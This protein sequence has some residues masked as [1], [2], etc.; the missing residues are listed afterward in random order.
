MSD[1][2]ATGMFRAAATA[3]LEDALQA[4]PE[5]ATDLGDH[6]FDELIDDLSNV[7]LATR[8][9]LMRRHRAELASVDPD[10]L[11]AEDRVDL[12]ILIGHLDQEVFEIE[13]LATYTWDPCVYGVGEA[14]Y[15][16][17][18]R[19]VM[20]VAD[21]L[22]AI[23]ARLALFPGRL[24]LARHQ[25][26]APPR[27]HVETALIQHPGNVALVR[28]EVDRLLVAEPALR[29]EVEPAQQAV[30]QALEKYEGFLHSLL[31]GPHRDPRIGPDHF[32]RK[33]A[34]ALSSPMP[35]EQLLARA[36][37]RVEELHDMLAE[38]AK[39]YLA[40]E[41]AGPLKGTK[42]EVVRA[43]L[44]RV[45]RDAP[46]EST[47]VPLFEAALL[48]CT[49]M[50]LASGTVSVPEDPYRIE[51]IPVFRRGGSAAQCDSAG[52][53]EE[54]GETSLAVAP[55]PDDWS[56]EQKVS[57]YREYNT[58]MVTNLT[59]HEAMP[60]HML[61]Q[62]HAR[63]FQGSTLVRKILQSGTFVEGW[64]VHAERIMAEAG[65]GGLPVRLQQLKLQLRVAINAI[66]DVSVHAGEMSQSEALELMMTRGYQEESEARGKWRRACLTSA[67][68]ST[69]FV[70]YTELDELFTALGDRLDYDELLAHGSPPPTLLRSVLRT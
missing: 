41:G 53:L 29:A 60:G 45:A 66:L 22:R 3:T 46:D 16:L 18:T 44:G 50:V 52:P 49:E 8:A 26:E 69:Y 4:R 32:S 21:R 57:F 34:L 48:R 33:L 39:E 5:W 9:Q 31:D 19:E 58:A 38:V 13:S 7:G 11:G 24:E 30:L 65:N 15:P 56:A 42:E 12:S 6:R 36:L 67:Q 61:Q 55:P 35:P 1:E 62:A 10:A 40:A 25:L 51:L 54:G 47:F 27:V 68:L 37:R 43:A 14:L 63:R 59:A 20:P 64:A 2:S 23:A 70:G 28:D 17:V